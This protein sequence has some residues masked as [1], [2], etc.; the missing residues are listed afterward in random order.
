MA[1][2]ETRTGAV[3][4][5][6]EKGAVIIPSAG[7]GQSPRR[8]ILPNSVWHKTGS[9]PT[10][11]ESLPESEPETQR[12]LGALTV[13]WTP[14][15]GRGRAV[16]QEKV[17][18]LGVPSPTTNRAPCL[19]KARNEKAAWPSRGR[20][21]VRLPRNPGLGTTHVESRSCPISPSNRR[22]LGRVLPPGSLLTKWVCAE[23]APATP[24]QF[25]G[26]AACN[27][28][29]SRAGNTNHRQDRSPHVNVLRCM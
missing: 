9:V 7:A 26:A 23:S 20:C 1:R 13:V 18:R 4:A 2:V 25:R 24:R 5:N 19:S 15:L 11:L 8:F 22:R 16:H 17:A 10:R 12:G 28:G 3:G 27:A 21:E 29:G 14:A 6:S